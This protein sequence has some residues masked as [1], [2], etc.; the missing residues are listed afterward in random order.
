MRDIVLTLVFAMAL[1]MF[2]VFPAVKI[3]DFIKT[4]R[5]LTPRM[6]NFLTLIFTILL[7][8]AGALFLKL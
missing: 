3:V 6:Q 4:R 5:T 1:L 7:A 2:A 8:L